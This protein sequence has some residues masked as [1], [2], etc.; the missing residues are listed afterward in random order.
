MTVY[1]EHLQRCRVCESK[2]LASVLDLGVTPLADRLVKEKQLGDKELL[3]PLTLVF[4]QSCSLA[5]LEQTV[6]P[7]LLFVEDYPYYSSVSPSLPRDKSCR[8]VA[9]SSSVRQAI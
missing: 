4:C 6:S 3:V 9:R 8:A 1:S 7:E 5:Q 2:D